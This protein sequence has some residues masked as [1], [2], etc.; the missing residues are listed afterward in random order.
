MQNYPYCEEVACVRVI[1]AKKH[2]WRHIARG[3]TCV[4]T[5]VF[6]PRPSVTEVDKFQV[7]ILLKNQIMRADVTMNHTIAMD[8]L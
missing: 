6:H 7:T 4:C 2:F 3:S 1:L 5:V 8:K